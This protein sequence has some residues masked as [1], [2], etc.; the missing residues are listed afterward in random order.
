MKVEMKLYKSF[1]AD[2]IALNEN[3]ISVPKLMKTA[4][5]GY[6]RGKKP[7]IYIPESKGFSLD[8]R[9][10]YMHI[11]IYLD[12]EQSIN[13]LKTKIKYRQ[14]SAFLKTLTRSCIVTPQVAVYFDNE[15]TIKAQ[16]RFN[17]EIDLDKIENLYIAKFNEKIIQVK[18]NENIETTKITSKPILK[19]KV[20]NQKNEDIFDEDINM[21]DL[22]NFELDDD[23]INEIEEIKEL[24]DY[25]DN[26]IGMENE[27]SEESKENDDDLFNQFLKMRS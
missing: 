17:N 8:G 14:R 21:E 23:I 4:L 7:N 27:E 15:E 9:K 6:V 12:D 1:D 22:E 24:H 16:N 3:G 19:N 5:E 20:T 13:F 10:R 18:N 25:N 26:D 11:A 2:F